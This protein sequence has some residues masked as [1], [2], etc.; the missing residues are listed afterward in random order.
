MTA[1]ADATG[2]SVQGVSHRY[3]K[4]L[5]LDE[6][7]LNLPA[8]QL[9][10]LVGPD[11]VGKSTLLGLISGAKKIQSGDIS[12]LGGSISDA[13]HRRRICSAIAFMPV[14]STHLRAH[15]T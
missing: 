10:G 1:M 5:A 12:V 9:V 4:L 2:I 6:L 13:A 8:G 3:R 15:E 14:S 11:G 7:T